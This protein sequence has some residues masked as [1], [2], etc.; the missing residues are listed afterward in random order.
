M[1]ATTWIWM[2]GVCGQVDYPGSF[3]ELPGPPAGQVKLP[4]I[5][6]GASGLTLSP[7]RMILENRSQ[8]LFGDAFPSLPYSLLLGGLIAHS[9]HLQPRGRTSWARRGHTFPPPEP[10]ARESGPRRAVKLSKSA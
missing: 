7:Q 8:C 4:P 2:H 9:A 1:T 3:V 6:R 10:P 5:S